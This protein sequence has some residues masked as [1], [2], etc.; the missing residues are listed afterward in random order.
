MFT[1]LTSVRLLG[2]GV[3]TCFLYIR[4]SICHSV[5]IT[6]RRSSLVL[7]LFNSI[8]SVWVQTRLYKIH[9]GRTILIIIVSHEEFYLRKLED[10]E[11]RRCQLVT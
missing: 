11:K 10:P 7:W 9:Y 2:Q 8:I 5:I 6:P 4:T 1:R 3:N